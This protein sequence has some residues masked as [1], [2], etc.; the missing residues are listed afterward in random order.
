MLWEAGGSPPHPPAVL[1]AA[2]CPSQPDAIPVYL[3]FSHSLAP[4][5]RLLG[6]IDSGAGKNLPAEYEHKCRLMW[7]SDSLLYLI[8]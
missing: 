5:F 3:M 6:N 7:A 1:H 8:K 4:A 2:T